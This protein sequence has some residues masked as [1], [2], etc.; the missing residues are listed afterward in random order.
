MSAP[1]RR[2]KAEQRQRERERA[3][4]AAAAAL[5]KSTTYLAEEL[6]EAVTATA[7]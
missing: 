1:K 6:L 4:A 7:M 3:A 2:E 5:R